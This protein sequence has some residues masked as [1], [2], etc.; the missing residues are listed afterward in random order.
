MAT[1]LRWLCI[2][3][4]M[5]GSQKKYLTLN[6]IA[7]KKKQYSDSTLEA[8]ITMTDT[9]YKSLI[10]QMTGRERDSFFK[11]GFTT[12]KMGKRTITYVDKV[13]WVNPDK[14]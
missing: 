10:E 9:S 6:G 1:G 7:K 3:E 5:L 11:F 4:C 12:R 14:K 2:I 8:I 13:L